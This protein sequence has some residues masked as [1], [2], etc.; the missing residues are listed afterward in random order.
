MKRNIIVAS[1]TIVLGTLLVLDLSSPT[2]EFSPEWGFIVFA[3]LGLSITCLP[4]AITFW[5]V[6]C[7][8]DDNDFFQTWLGH[9]HFSIRLQ[10]FFLSTPYYLYLYVYNELNRK[11]NKSFTS[12]YYD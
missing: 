3:Y 9:V 8:L 10:V 4:G 2:A 6:Y 12:K 5:Y 11:K 7:V 1:L